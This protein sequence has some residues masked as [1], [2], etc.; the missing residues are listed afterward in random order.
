MKRIVERQTDIDTQTRLRKINDETE[1][2][3]PQKVGREIGQQIM[4]ARLQKKLTQKQL[5]NIMCKHI[6]I[7]SSFENGTAIYDA[8]ILQQFQRVLQIPSFQ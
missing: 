3:I 8:K 4:K 5:A 2:F 1:T 7:I 6:S